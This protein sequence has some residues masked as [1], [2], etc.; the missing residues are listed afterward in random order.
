MTPTPFELEIRERT[1]QGVVVLELHGELDI[2][3]AADV[4]QS[5]KRHLNAG[6]DV[7]VDLDSLAFIDSSGIRVLLQSQVMAVRAEHA[8]T[9]SRGSPEVRRVFALVGLADQFRYRNE[10]PTS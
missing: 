5:V 7:S 6:S 10:A 9:I 3:S 1:E 4:E 2:A 8:F